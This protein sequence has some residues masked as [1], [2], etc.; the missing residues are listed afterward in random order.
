MYAKKM[1]LTMVTVQDCTELL[2]LSLSS[3]YSFDL[4]V[5]LYHQSELPLEEDG[6]RPAITSAR[7][8]SK[9]IT[10]TRRYGAT[11]KRAEIWAS[12]THG[13]NVTMQQFGI[14]VS[15]QPQKSTDHAPT[16]TPCS[17]TA[18]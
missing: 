12:E 15:Q 8:R 6:Y 10:S 14:M 13:Q 1:A 3:E 11:P 16:I 18:V 5:E 7:V 9:K 17:L 4:D 2:S